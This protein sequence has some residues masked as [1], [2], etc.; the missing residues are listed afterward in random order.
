MLN[1]DKAATDDEEVETTT[2]TLEHF[3]R[4]SAKQLI[5]QQTATKT[6]HKPD[7]HTQREKK[8]A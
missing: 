6:T 4:P 2:K 1:T 7:A 8:K 5:L 3:S